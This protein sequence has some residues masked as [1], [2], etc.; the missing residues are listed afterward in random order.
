MADEARAIAVVLKGYPRLS[1]TFIAQELHA[2]EQH[3]LCLRLYSLRDPTDGARHPVHE[4]IAAPVTYLPEYLVDDPLRVVK[5]LLRSLLLPGFFPA[6]RVFLK[7][8]WRE[9]DVNRGRR[10]GQAVV[11]ACE[12]PPD[13]TEIYSHFLHTPS[14]VAR[15]AAIMRRLSWSFSAHA[16]D[17]WTIP[18]WEKSEKIRDA[19]W[20]TT[21]TA[22]NLEHLRSLAPRGHQAK[23]FL[24]YHGLDLAR[25]PPPPVRAARRGDDPD[26]PLRIVSVGRAV[27]KKGYDVLLDALSRL[28]ASLYW[29]FLHIG[30]GENAAALRQLADRLGLAERIEWRGAQ[31]QGEV[32]G[33]LR[34][35]DLFVLA[36]RI[37]KSGD[38]D[39]L[40]NVLMEA[41]SQALCCLST[42]V[43]AIP[44]FILDKQTG[45]LVPPEDPDALAQA[46]AQLAKNPEM[47][48]SL[49][50][51]ART[52]LVTSFSKDAC[53]RSLAARFGIN[54]NARDAAGSR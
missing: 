21:C 43:S 45:C 31:P 23:L 40:P 35:G 26:D 13:V 6:L 50:Q 5:G 42:S 10:F 9:R 24:S 46:I 14:S 8:W 27:P 16:K 47:R 22:A 19:R 7:D 38:R 15:Y 12:M 3:G 18:A 44:E 51:A 17:I 34:E 52:R 32:I 20:G 2:L 37:D 36:S 53:I 39:G 4:E 48:F 30:G 29:R 1:E 25:F 41:A 49:G 28:P 54:D 33:L 11:L